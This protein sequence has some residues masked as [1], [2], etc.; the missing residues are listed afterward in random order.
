MNPFR[1]LLNEPKEYHQGIDTDEKHEVHPSHARLLQQRTRSCDPGVLLLG[2]STVDLNGLVGY[3]M[4]YQCY[5]PKDYRGNNCE[6][7]IRPACTFGLADINQTVPDVSGQIVLDCFDYTGLMDV[8][9]FKPALNSV[10]NVSTRALWA[11]D[12]AYY[13]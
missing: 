5:C 1:A 7:P 8:E 6:K 3:V 9:G 11:N 12:S 4:S 13:D 2:F 10:S